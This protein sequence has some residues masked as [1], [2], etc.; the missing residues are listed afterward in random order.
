MAFIQTKQTLLSQS[1]K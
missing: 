1:C